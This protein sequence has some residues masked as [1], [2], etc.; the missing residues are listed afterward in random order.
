MADETLNIEWVKQIAANQR[1][2]ST[3]FARVNGKDCIVKKI[4]AEGEKLES[5]VKTLKRQVRFSE[6]LNEEEQ[7][8][9]CLFDMMS[10]IDGNIVFVRRWCEGK[11]L[12]EQL[13]QKKRFSVPEA[14]NMIL[15]IARI[16]A[17]AHAHNVI[18]GDLKPA[19]I[20]VSESEEI[21]IID[22]DTMTIDNSVEDCYD[23]NRSV[24]SEQVVGTPQ[25]MPVE[26]YQG[27]LNVQCDVY[28]LGVILYQ[29]LTGETPFDVA[30]PMITTQMAIYKQKHEVQNNHQLLL[31]QLSDM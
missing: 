19:N 21:T 18:H 3:W 27:E 23:K 29:L 6:I 30:E 10:E 16:V 26:Q 7:K 13:V 24:S 9:I 17:T 12:D 22:W 8:G 20:I 4:S 1:Y 11:T 28:A 25:Y 15:K 5:L 14:V 2:R 31:L